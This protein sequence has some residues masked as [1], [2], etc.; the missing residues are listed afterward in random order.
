LRRRITLIRYRVGDRVGDRDRVR[1]RVRVRGF[2]GRA[3]ES[4]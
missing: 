3:E 1:I 4:F 2:E